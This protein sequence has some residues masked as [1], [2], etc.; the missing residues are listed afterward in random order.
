MCPEGAV[1]LLRCTLCFSLYLLP[2]P[3]YLSTPLFFS[4][5]FLPLCYT[6]PLFFSFLSSFCLHH[7][8]ICFCLFL[9]PLSPSFFP[10]LLLL[11]FFSLCLSPL[12]PFPLFSFE[13]N[14]FLFHPHLF[15]FFFE[16]IACIVCIEGIACTLFM[17]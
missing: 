7:F 2:L 14:H 1:H 6:S 16:G 15:L 4:L 17:M 11:A 8:L 9:S 13:I 12:S 5:F 10:L 3:F